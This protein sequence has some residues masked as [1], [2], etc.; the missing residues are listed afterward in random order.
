MGGHSQPKDTTQGKDYDMM[1]GIYHGHS[2]KFVWKPQAGK[3]D[4]GFHRFRVGKMSN[5][6]YTVA[7]KLTYN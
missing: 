7:I 3:L 4:S 1:R 6:K 2:I 5:N